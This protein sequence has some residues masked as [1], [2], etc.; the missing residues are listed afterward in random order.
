MFHALPDFSKKKKKERKILW[1]LKSGFT[2]RPGEIENFRHMSQKSLIM[3]LV[4]SDSIQWIVVRCLFFLANTFILPR[5]LQN[6]E[7]YP[8]YLKIHFIDTHSG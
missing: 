6:T 4:P 2:L 7:P 8:H 3:L 5:K 1:E